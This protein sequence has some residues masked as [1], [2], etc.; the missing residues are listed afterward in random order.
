MRPGEPQAVR[1][2]R[3]SESNPES[4]EAI[5]RCD[6]E[7][8]EPERATRRDIKVCNKRDGGADMTQGIGIVT[9]CTLPFIGFEHISS[10]QG[11][12]LRMF[13][14]EDDREQR[15]A[16]ARTFRVIENGIRHETFDSR[17]DAHDVNRLS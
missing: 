6:P 7:S 3:A 11:A 10:C 15:V 13:Q 17:H 9:F 14:S 4:D 16:R 2:S 1:E 12:A 8:L 5:I